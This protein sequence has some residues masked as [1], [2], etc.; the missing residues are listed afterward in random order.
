MAGMYGC[1]KGRNRDSAAMASG[2]PD[3]VTSQEPA[4]V[5]EDCS[6]LFLAGK[7]TLHFPHEHILTT[8]KQSGGSIIPG[9]AFLQQ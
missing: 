3:L 1:F 6:E 4:E 2:S 5:Q 9:D 7:P 8:V